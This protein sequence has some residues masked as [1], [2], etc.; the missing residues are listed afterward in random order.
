MGKYFI[1]IS[2][3]KNSKD[4]FLPLN[5][6]WKENILAKRLPSSLSFLSEENESQSFQY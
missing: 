1:N 5:L 6:K 2:D 4:S 3:T